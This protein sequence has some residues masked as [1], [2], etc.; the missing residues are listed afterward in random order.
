MKLV[1]SCE[2][3]GNKIPEQYSKYF[4]GKDK[5]LASHRGWDIGALSVA[6]SLSEH[7]KA[8]LFYATTSRLLVEL[9]RSLHHPHLFSAITKLLSTCEKEEILKANYF[10]YRNKV[11][12]HITS[13]IKNDEYVLHIS[14]HSFTPELNGELRN[15][16]IGLLY[17]PSSHAEKD[18]CLR[19]KEQIKRSGL[20]R[21]RY[22]YPY[23]GTADGFTT[24]L[25]KQFPEKYA[26]IELEINQALLRDKEGI[27]KVSKLLALSLKEMKVG[28]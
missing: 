22:N 28:I 18:F 13:L 27:E 10:P 2:H 19:W 6:K 21:V 17:D 20:L 23:R 8:P 3:G 25:R 11:K 9:N 24:Y 14:V 26:G 5:L 1:L 15:T 7:L 4:K 16:D 12:E